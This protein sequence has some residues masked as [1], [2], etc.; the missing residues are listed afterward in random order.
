[1]TLTEK[2]I[3]TQLRKH[4]KRKLKL[5]NGHCQVTI[6]RLGK[7]LFAKNGMGYKYKHDLP[8]AGTRQKIYRIAEE[9][10]IE[11][12]GKR[13]SD[14]YTRHKGRGQKVGRLYQF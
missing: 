10:C 7:C 9:L 11:H 1:M 4:L 2:E 12:G 8:G 14:G 3:R 13:I 6:R 5:G